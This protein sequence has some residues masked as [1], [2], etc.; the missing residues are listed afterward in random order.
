MKRT[1]V[2][3][4][5]ALATVSSVAI[6]Q[7]ASTDNNVTATSAGLQ[8]QMTTGLQQSGFSDVKVIPGSFYVRAHDQSGNP[9]AMFITPNSMEEV[10]TVGMNNNVHQTAMTNDTSN[11]ATIPSTDELS[12]KVIGLDVYNNDN[13]DIGTIKDIAINSNGDVKGYILSVGGFIGIG[14]HYVAVRPSAIHLTYNATDAKWH[15]KMDANAGQLKSAPE[16][17]YPSKA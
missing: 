6:A 4:A 13:K 8:Q 14:D 16:Y 9:V 1:L 15:A 17:K 5:V 10:T 7:A 12:S 11:F 3:A 2:V